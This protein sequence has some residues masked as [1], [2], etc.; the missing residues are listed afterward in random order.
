M[1]PYE[2]L[3]VKQGASQEEI[4]AAYR[5]LVKQYHPDQYGDNPLKD[6]AQEKLTEVNKAYDMLKNGGGNSGGTY[7]SNY[8]SN[9][10]SSYNSG[11]SNN[12]A[13]YAEIR[14]LIQMRNNIE[15]ERRLNAMSNRDAEWHFLYGAVQLNKGWFD[16]ALSNI[17]RACQMDPNNFEYRQSLNQLKMR[18]GGYANP[19]R[20]AQGGVDACTCCNNLICA[21]CCCEMMGGDLIGCC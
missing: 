3:G 9:S 11:Y 4:K 21:D 1:N 19:Y 15:A 10:N 13:G 12:V 2:V 7:S 8:S 5:K 14:R 16:S 20:T 17:E 18:A 6:L